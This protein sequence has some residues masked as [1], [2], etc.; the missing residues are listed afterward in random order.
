MAAVLVE[1]DLITDEVRRQID[2]IIDQLGENEHREAISD[3]D[4][5]RA[6]QEL[7]DLGLSA[8][9]IAKKRHI[10][11]KRVKTAVQVAKSTVVA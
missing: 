9:Q 5:V 1:P 7:L 8:G 6:T 11:T 3:A 4:E 2:R 10:G